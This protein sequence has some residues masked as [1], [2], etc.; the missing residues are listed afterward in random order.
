MANWVFHVDTLDQADK[1]RST[2]KKNEN[3]LLSADSFQ[4]GDKLHSAD[5]GEKGKTN[6]GLK[7]KLFPRT[8]FPRVG[9][10]LPADKLG[11]GTV[12]NYN[13]LTIEKRNLK[14]WIENKIVF[15]GQFSTRGLNSRSLTNWTQMQNGGHKQNNEQL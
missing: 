8:I 11:F 12:T 7:R 10:F 4:H 6:S 9:N 3:R 15:R 14:S 2:K 5:N 1:F 13:P